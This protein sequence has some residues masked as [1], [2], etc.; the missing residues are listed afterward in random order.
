LTFIVLWRKKSRPGRRGI[1]FQRLIDVG[2]PDKLD[3]AQIGAIS[4]DRMLVVKGFAV[5]KK[6][7]FAIPTLLIV[8][9]V[10]IWLV[11]N[12]RAKQKYD[13]AMQEIRQTQYAAVELEG[14]A[15][16][17]LAKARSDWTVHFAE[18][19][20]PY[21]E[22]LSIR[23]LPPTVAN[24]VDFITRPLPEYSFFSA[25]RNMKATEAGMIKALICPIT[26]DGSIHVS[27][28]GQLA[29]IQ[30]SENAILVVEDSE[31]GLRETTYVNIAP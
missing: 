14:D 13:L 26:I 27:S 7:I 5:M 1:R 31:E 30:L 2:L 15:A 20:G 10:A 22:A 29:L 11:M 6:L 9:A 12:L 4:G 8:V 3:R 25:E 17:V 18:V 24:L 16:D 19:G 28:D 21:S 23:G